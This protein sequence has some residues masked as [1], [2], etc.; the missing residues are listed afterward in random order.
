MYLPEK[1]TIHKYLPAIVLV[2]FTVA[3]CLVPVVEI[4]NRIGNDWQ[5]IP[6]SVIDDDVYYYGRM[7]DAVKGN[8]FLGNPYFI[9][10]KDAL[11]PAFFVP[12][13]ISALPIFV[14]IS[15]VPSLI[16]NFFFW[17]IIFTL[18]AY[19][20]AREYELRP[21]PAVFISLFAFVEVY[22]LIMRPISM[23]IVFP[24]FLFFLLA[25]LLWLKKKDDKRRMVLLV[26]AS[27]LT[28]YLYTYMWQIVCII[29]GV[30]FLHQVFMK[31]W[32]HVKQLLIV[33]T[34]VIVLSIPVLFYT[35]KQ[36]QTEYYWETFRRIGLV[37]THLPTIYSYQYGRWVIVL[38]LAIF[39]IQ[40]IKKEKGEMPTDILFVIYSGLG[41]FIMS[42]SNFIT[43][44]E[45]ETALHAG[46]FITLWFALFG[47]ILLF[48][49]LFNKEFTWKPLNWVKIF[50]A[51]LVFL[52]L[53]FLVSNMRRSLPFSKIAST[54]FKQY[55]EYAPPLRWLDLN[56]PEQS[57]IW[58]NNAMSTYIPIMTDNYVL[59]NHLGA[60]HLM[61]S[62][63]V[64]DRYLV[65]WIGTS[66]SPRELVEHYREYAGA[67]EVWDYTDQ[68]YKNRLRCIMRQTCEADQEFADWIG[69]GK[70]GELQVRQ[71]ELKKD[72][73]ATLNKY[74][75]KAVVADKTL[76]EDKYFDT[77]SMF[78]KVWNNE[79]FVIYE[80]VLYKEY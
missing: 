71:T 36:I 31:R 17:A 78:E 3:L 24:A 69:T 51:V 58:A 55:Q 25:F 30:A 77:L 29:L 8:I 80:N 41:L 33:G 52:T 28:F 18:L 54:N 14:G 45:L 12:D 57:V 42:V 74:S 38:L 49:W 56:L 16:F 15:L 37:A 46:R 10:Y 79:R 50:F 26:V 21:W 64:R 72:M 59:W 19:R 40:K 73:Q 67:G 47:A 2:L 65:A 39:L 66:S 27:S 61:P 60:L 7:M 22:W 63:E 32:V 34:S 13:L 5:G 35:V 48:K 1:R 70:I 4:G 11:S 20:L 23:Q 6:P 62:D 68:F 44:K 9:E 53:G 75:V 43:G 76:G